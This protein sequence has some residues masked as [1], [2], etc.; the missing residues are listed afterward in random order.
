[1]SGIVK[2]LSLNVFRLKCMWTS[3]IKCIYTQSLLTT[4][5]YSI[6]HSIQC[7]EIFEKRG[8]LHTMNC[9]WNRIPFAWHDATVKV[10][11]GW[12]LVN[13]GVKG[14]FPQHVIF[15]VS[16]CTLTF[17]PSIQSEVCLSVAEATHFPRVVIISPISSP[18]HHVKSLPTMFHTR[19][20][21]PKQGPGTT[22]IFITAWVMSAV[23]WFTNA[24]W[25]P[26][27]A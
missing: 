3:D 14:G 8:T 5:L 25:S 15:I 17:L 1:M 23:H 13:V 19:G 21:H 6:T 22:Y 10:E 20:F 27:N 24:E 18:L 11:C 12:K 26:H 4:T 7:S 9:L 16:T 2:N